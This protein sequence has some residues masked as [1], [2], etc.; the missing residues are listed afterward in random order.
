MDKP[1]PTNR[2]ILIVED[3]LDI[4]QLLSHFLEKSG[5]S[6][7]CAANGIEALEILRSGPGLPKLIILDIMMP[8]MDGFQFLAEQEKD[9]KIAGIPVVAMTADKTAETRALH[10]GVKAFLRKPFTEVEF[11]LRTIEQFLR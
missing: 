1:R 8:E 5:Y 3:S 7:V 10:A 9:S 11:I 6:V 4:Q 2:Q